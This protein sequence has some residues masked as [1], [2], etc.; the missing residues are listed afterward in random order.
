MAT[1]SLA[2]LQADVHE[3]LSQYHRDGAVANPL[4]RYL[5]FQ[6]KQR[7][8]PGHTRQ[9][10][11]QFLLEAL[12]TLEIQHPPEAML[13]RL[14]FLDEALVQTVANKLNIS[15]SKVYADQRRALTYLA[16]IMLMMEEQAQQTNRR[17]LEHRLEPPN[18][19]GLVGVE[20]LL[21]ALTSPCVTTTAPWLIA[22]TGM[23]GIGKTTLADALVR[24][25]IEVDWLTDLAWV[26]ARQESFHLGGGIQPV[27][28]PALTVP[29]LVNAL[30]AQLWDATDTPPALSSKEATLFLEQRLKARPHLIVIDNLETLV[31]LA[32]LLPTLRRLANP[33]KF[34]LTSRWSLQGEPDVY[35]FQVPELSE[36]DALALIR[37]EVQVRNLSALATATTTDLRPIYTLVG[38]NPLA[39]RLVVGQSQWHGLATVLRDLALVH[40]QKSEHF[41]TFLYRRAWEHLDEVSRRVWLAMPLAPKRGADRA[42]L[43]ALCQLA[44]ADLQHGIEQLLALNLIDSRGELQVRRYTIHNLTRTFLQQG[45][46]QWS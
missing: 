4:T 31:D 7:S 19:T 20:T 40:G 45:I 21:D 10:S 18:H 29:A 5:C 15:E 17:R 14:R 6:Q 1:V 41:Y 36:A 22:L 23:G 13:L 34:L 32:T 35:Q 24:R 42:Y 28:Q 26:S 46:A 9:V 38:G 44:S 11:N 39:L 2:Q 33:T 43:T 8:N 3:A 37:Q 27:A 30:V 12:Q 25:L 16:E